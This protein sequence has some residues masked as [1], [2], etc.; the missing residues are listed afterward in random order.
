MTTEIALSDIPGGREL[1]DWFGYVPRF[2]DANLLGINLVSDGP[3]S[4]RIHAF[5]MTKEVDDRG[6]YVLDKHVVVT[7]TLEAVIQVG[8]SDF[9]LPGIIFELSFSTVEDDI[10]LAWTGSYGVEGTIRAK[11][12]RIDLIPGKPV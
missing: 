3:S 2:H 5:R 6:Y 9:N 10:Q 4:L 8:L 7:V 12:A 11:Q 1:I